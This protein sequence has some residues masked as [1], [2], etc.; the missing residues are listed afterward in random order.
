[1]VIRLT[2]GAQIGGALRYNEQKVVQKQAHVLSATGFANN[3]LAEKNRAYATSVLECQARKN[4]NIKKPTL[5]FSLSLHPS[6]QVSDEKFKVM[7]H[8]FMAE[9]GYQNQ[10]YV[11][12]RHHD[13]AHP[14]I[15]IVTTCVNETGNKINDSHIKR[16][17]NSVRQKLELRFGLIKAQGRGKKKIAQQ[18]QTIAQQQAQTLNPERLQKTGGFEKKDQLEAILRQT[19]QQATFNSLDE[20]RALLKKQHVRT[21][22]HQ[23]TVAGKT[24]RGISYQFTDE[25]GKPETP[26]IKA[27]EIGAWATWKEIEKQFG[28]SGQPKEQSQ[29]NQLNAE[30]YKALASILSELVREYKKEQ[31]IYYESALIEGFPTSVMRDRLWVLTKESLIEQQVSEAVKR[32]EEYKRAQLAEIIRKEQVS[33]IRTMETYAKIAGEIQGSS[34]DKHNFFTALSVTLTADGLLSSPTNRH[35][36]YQIEPAL[37]DRIKTDEGADLKIPKIYSRGERAVMLLSES[38]KAFRESYYDVR[39]EHLEGILTSDRMSAIHA[40]LNANYV[41]RLAIDGPVTGVDLIRYYYQR[42]ILID[43]QPTVTDKAE[44]T[45]A[46]RIRYKDAPAQAA[47][48]PSR[49]FEK[50]IQH[51]NLTHWHNGLS[52]EAGRYMVALAQLIDQTRDTNGISTDLT[53]LRERIQQRDPALAKLSYDD[54]VSE[55][56]KRSLNGNGWIKQLDQETKQE[57]GAYMNES[58]INA[59][60]VDIRA[61]DVLGYEQTGKFKHVGRGI[62]KRSKGRE[63]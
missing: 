12:Y 38:G 22:L 50:Q 23:S 6:E 43:A 15:H 20:Y 46:Y 60:L 34:Q 39:S 40:Q 35:L 1:M 33:F 53:Y 2:V 13:T 42:G 21:V 44:K 55:L 54:L 52:T 61:A 27:S 32:F 48:E 25:T 9:M 26:R 16:R 19:F 31:R 41:A 24:I 30:Q 7:A 47:V 10:P 18:A 3:D 11:V 28:Q 5:H 58:A 62:K 59:Q 4:A 63:L 49:S 29:P 51:L 8:Q 45:S 36:V 56:E 57:P 14:H 37:Y 17:T